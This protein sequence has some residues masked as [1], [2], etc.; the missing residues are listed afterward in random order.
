MKLSFLLLALAALLGCGSPSTQA[1]IYID[2]KK[3]PDDMR[4]DYESFAV[5]CSKCHSLARAFNANVT[6]PSHW[7]LYVARMMRTAGSSISPAEKPHILRFLHW[8]TE[9]YEPAEKAAGAAKEI[10]D[11]NS[12]E[13]S[14]A[15]AT[16]P[17][18]SE[19]MP[20][21]AVAAPEAPPPPSAAPAPVSE[22]P[23]ASEVPATP[24]AEDQ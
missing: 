23:H 3:I 17:R 24:P 4:S 8:Y 2:E 7:D 13:Q 12:S 20:A 21:P 15:P 1:T 16:K 5:N 10:A 14:P 9:K 22:P 19:S 18:A 6:D 11:E